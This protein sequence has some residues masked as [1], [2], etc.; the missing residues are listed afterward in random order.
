MFDLQ[1]MF[2]NRTVFFSHSVI[3]LYIKSYILNHDKAHS[4]LVA[5]MLLQG[6]NITQLFLP[7]QTLVSF[8]KFYFLIIQAVQF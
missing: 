8:G 4:K 6:K 1:R 2:K 5:V 3:K 7:R